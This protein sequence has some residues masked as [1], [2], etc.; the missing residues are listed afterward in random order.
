MEGEFLS[1][2][3]CKGSKPGQ[4]NYPWDVACN[5]QDQILVSDTRDHRIQVTHFLTFINL[6]ILEISKYFLLVN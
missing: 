1:G 6:P 2:F 4:F 5:K 3:G